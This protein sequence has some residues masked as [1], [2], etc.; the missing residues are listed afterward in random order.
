[1]QP[2]RRS[3][4]ADAVNLTPDAAVKTG[5]LSEDTTVTFINTRETGELTIKKTVVSS[6]AA[7]K[8]KEFHF[9]VTLT[10][11]N[12]GEKTYSGVKFTNGVSE[13][14]T[15]KH[16]ESR[17][18]KGLPAG[19]EYSV[20]EVEKDQNN[21]ATSSVGDTGIIGAT[22]TSMAAFTNTKAEGGLVVSKKVISA[23]TDDH[24]K[25]EYD[26][27]I[28]LD[29][30]TITDTFGE[31]EFNGGVANFKIM[32]GESK[33]VLGLPNGTGYEVTEA[34]V[35]GMAVSYSTGCVGKIEENVT[36]HAEVTNKRG[37]TELT[38]KKIVESDIETD[39]TDETFHFKLSFSPALDGEYSGVYIEGGIA[40]L[41]LK[42]DESVT[43]KGIPYGT[44]YTVE[45]VEDKRF[46]TT[47][48][49]EESAKLT[50]TAATVTYTNTRKTGDLTISKEVDS[51]VAADHDG[52]YIF[53][54]QLIGEAVTG[55]FSGYQFID[56]YA[57]GIVVKEGES[58]TIKGLPAGVT[59][60]VVE[61]DVS[62]MTTNADGAEG[63]I[64]VNDAAVAMFTNT[65]VTGDLLLSKEVV[66]TNKADHDAEYIFKVTLNADVNG[67]FS[68]VKFTAGE[69]DEIKVKEGSD[70]T[71]KK[72]PAGIAYTVSEEEP[73]GF[74]VI[75]GGET[76]AI[77]KDQTESVKVTNIRN[78]GGLVITK[79]VISSV[80]DDHD[81][82]KF[83]FTVTLDDETISG[84][85][86]DLEF[87][88]GV[89]NVKL[90]DG[91]YAVVT[92]L[93]TGTKY[94][95]TEKVDKEIYTVAA[96]EIKD[97]DTSK[98]TLVADQTQRAD[99]VNTRKTTSLK[100]T[101]KVDSPLEEDTKA[102]Y[103]FFLKLKNDDEVLNGTYGGYRFSSG[104]AM[105][106][107][108]GGSS[109]KIDQIPLGTTYEIREAVEEGAFEV[110]INGEK[111]TSAKGKIASDGSSEIIVTNKRVL[112]KIKVTKVWSDS[113]NSDGSRPDAVDIRIMANGRPVRSGQLNK[114]NNWTETFEDL[115]KY[116]AGGKEVLY[117]VVE[118]PVVGY[119]AS[120]KVTKAS[121]GSETGNTLNEGSVEIT[122]KHEPKKTTPPTTPTTTPPTTPEKPTTPSTP[123]KPT[124]PET[125]S[126]PSTP[127]SSAAA[128][129]SAASSSGG[130]SAVSRPT[131]GGGGGTSKPAPT[132]PV[133]TGDETP[134]TLYLLLMLAAAAVILEE[135]IR[136]RRKN[137]G[138]G[139]K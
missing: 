106:W 96:D 87:A 81:K 84:T 19:V 60:K 90:G 101:K 52:E 129:S 28:T 112:T 120:Y 35:E 9:V 38:I 29:D 131:S 18:I 71:I 31:V 39:K 41:W 91:E 102:K 12:E 44:T 109:V 132:A 80:K 93:P 15:L 138:A 51:K 76:G 25:A 2:A 103:C 92:G 105:I 98:G 125:P 16:N 32:E 67:E 128:S 110:T 130:S 82:G 135:V 121:G 42:H 45:E 97:Q 72:L 62:D 94:T 6:T 24:D 137:K 134:I 117:T 68:G 115:P 133:K 126:K 70:V 55:K 65:R 17:T 107:V 99:F 26:I 122:N 23:I 54:I 46:E 119:T 58:V 47:V 136:R 50:D 63:Q 95:V 85:Y 104:E 139:R 113:D 22:G 13:K 86:G 4:E 5:T 37:T 56:G 100:L 123:T 30:K 77:S 21:F 69:S 11:V 3:T 34:D 118:A 116:G 79:T 108:A 124:V 48:D 61:A 10:G 7:D 49:G 40:N 20:V 73:E 59:Y 114:S 89:S 83:E 57:E 14:I 36:K 111:G 64:P 88:D 66:S 43:I 127:A 75:Y 74:T 53:S 1:M 33:V 27:T 78:E 8:D